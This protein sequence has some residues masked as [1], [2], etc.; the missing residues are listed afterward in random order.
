MSSMRNRNKGYR[1]LKIVG[2]V[3]AD[4]L[5]LGTQVGL[6]AFQPLIDDLPTRSQVVRQGQFR[7][8]VVARVL[9]RDLHSEVG[10]HREVGRIDLGTRLVGMNRCL[11]I[12]SCHHRQREED[13]G[14]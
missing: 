11:Y 9:H 12:L 8:E 2:A 5:M 1:R 3:V 14:H 10:A 6:L 13:D 4:I 7:H